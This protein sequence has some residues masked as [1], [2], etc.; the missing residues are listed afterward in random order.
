MLED[1]LVMRV[2]GNR[3]IPVDF[4]LV[5]ATNRDLTALVREGAF[6]EDLYYRLSVFKVDIAPLRMRGSDIIELAEFFISSI[7]QSQQLKRPTLCNSTKYIL[8]QY[9]WPGN[10]RQLQNAIAYAVCMCEEGTLLPEH[11]PKEVMDNSLA[12]VLENA[13]CE[14]NVTDKNEDNSLSMKDIEKIVIKKALDDTNNHI[15]AA[16]KVLGISKSTIYRK[17]KEY[18]IVT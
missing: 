1:K 5:A 9:P 6:R 14:G 11:L 16:A 15:R 12:P 2:G 17:I 18:D 7:T 4:R 13:P 10:V 8:L 3:Y